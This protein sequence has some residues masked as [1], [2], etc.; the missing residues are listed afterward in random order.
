MVELFNRTL[1]LTPHCDDETIGC[2]GLIHKLHRTNPSS[3]I[4]IVVVARDKSFSTSVSRYVSIEERT[5][6]MKNALLK[7]GGNIK[8]EFL[9]ESEGYS[10]K[11]GEL[12]LV[13]KRVYVT[14]LDKIINSFKPSAV[15]FP[16]ASHHQD[17][18]LVNE[19]VL[20]SLRPSF[21]TNFIK[22]KAMYEYPYY[23]S[24]NLHKVDLTKLYVDL[25]ESDIAAKSAAL[26][27]YRSQVQRN[28]L[29]PLDQSAILDLAKVRGRE[30]STMFAEVLYPLSTVF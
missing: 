30:V 14:E 10:Y 7:L 17:H 19:V 12:D 2:G 20:A 1:I 21:S 18:K 24:W 22:L 28:Q 4:F 3:E 23:D 27:C 16:Y 11:D 29:D 26:G 9:S 25:D 13:P 6:E 8:V 15:L 5:D